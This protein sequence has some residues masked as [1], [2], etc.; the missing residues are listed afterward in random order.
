[1]KAKKYPLPFD[2]ENLSKTAKVIAL[3]KS[4][5]V[6]T[7]RAEILDIGCGT[8]IYTLPLAREA[9]KVTG[10]DLSKTMLDHFREEAERQGL[11]NWDVIEASWDSLDVSS[12]GFLK[13]FDVV[14]IGHVH[15]RSSRRR[16]AQNDALLQEVVRLHRLGKQTE[17]HLDGGGL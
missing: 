12:R 11:F 4:R 8:G 6:E 13:G 14:W 5:G 10:V 9:L 16:G 7:A 3:V 2:P 17:G 1:M 15:G